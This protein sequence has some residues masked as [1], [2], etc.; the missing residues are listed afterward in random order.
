VAAVILAAGAGERLGGTVPKAFSR[1]GG[2]PMVAYSLRAASLCDRID[3][4]VLVVPAGHQAVLDDELAPLRAAVAAP[5][6][7]IE[8][9]VGGATRQESVRAGL[10]AAPG[11][12][13]VVVVHDAARPFATSRLFGQVIGALGG[14][15]DAR[16]GGD[17]PDGV[18]PALP[19]H[20]TI[21]RVRDG[22]I[23]ETVSRDELWLAQTPQ[24]FYADALRHAHESAV[25]R[26]LDATDDAMLLEAAGYRLAVIAGEPSNVKITTAE[27]LAR[28][29]RL[30][31]LDGSSDAATIGQYA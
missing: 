6:L 24:A 7:Q 13:G 28:A 23:V 30:I 16:S 21:K 4:I 20:D 19:C 18:V 27:D 17:G 11:G 12:T 3:R 15:L 9:V 5:D 1:L 2:R 10:A 14:G 22:L 25:E 31:G 26:G 8:T 29:E